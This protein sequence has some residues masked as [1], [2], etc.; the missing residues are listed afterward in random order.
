MRTFIKG[1]F[2]TSYF[3]LCPIER[4]ML[5][6]AKT[7]RDIIRDQFH[8]Q[9]ALGRMSD[10]GYGMIY[11]ECKKEFFYKPILGPGYIEQGNG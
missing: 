10:L 8:M 5:K 7:N 1:I 9:I 2:L 3:S 6:Q 11:G 4:D